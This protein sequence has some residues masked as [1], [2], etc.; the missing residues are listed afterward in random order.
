MKKDPQMSPKL[1]SVLNK[2]KKHNDGYL[3]PYLENII[4]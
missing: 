2:L 1:L 4:D 3:K